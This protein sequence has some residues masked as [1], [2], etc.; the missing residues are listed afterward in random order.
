MREPLTP[1]DCDLQDF[2][3]M[4]LHVARLRDSD[5]AGEVEPE[6][7]WYAVLLWAASWHQLPAA[8]LPD[9]DAVLTKLVGLGRD[10]KTFRKHRDGA[11]RGFVKCLDGRLYHPVVAEQAVTA[12]NS[13]LEQRWRT[14]CAR[15]KKAN[16][17]NGTSLGLPTFEQF[18]SGGRPEDVPRDTVGDVPAGAGSCPRGNG[19]QET[20]T[21]TGTGINIGPSLRSEP[22]A[23][24]SREL[25]AALTSAAEGGARELV[26]A[27]PADATA[28]QA[29]RSS[30][31]VTLQTVTA[32]ER[33]QF[34]N[35]W[36]VYPHRVSKQDALLAF[37][38]V[39]RA[40]DPTL[41]HLTERTQAYAEWLVATGT[42]PANGATWLN[43][44]RWE[45]DLT[46]I[47]HRTRGQPRQG[48]SAMDQAIAG[49][50]G[51]Q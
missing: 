40:S 9:N 14:E 1:S 42:L 20:G 43:G 25:I 10:I 44:R 18:L 34:E 50:E 12:W 24:P 38:K 36:A 17:R 30:R 22:D 46:V 27:A 5:L 13:K 31:A 2:P 48:W 41:D 28:P 7:A 47:S 35:W 45:D 4:P 26:P 6:A 11:L 39:Y 32:E 49:M 3:F 23:G 19:I 33:A 16:Q 37:A 8:S 15:I 51:E 29:K 21:G